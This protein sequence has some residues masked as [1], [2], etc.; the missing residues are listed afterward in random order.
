MNW[1]S[2]KEL[3]GYEHSELARARRD[4]VDRVVPCELG[5]GFRAEFVFLQRT[6]GEAR[7]DEADMLQCPLGRELGDD[8][9]G[10]VVYV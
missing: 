10:D 1:K 7:F 3:M 9:E 2:V 8:L 5:A 6:H 4:I